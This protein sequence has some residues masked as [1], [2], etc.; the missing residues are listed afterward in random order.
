MLS[1]KGIKTK[2]YGIL[3]I[4]LPEQQMLQNEKKSMIFQSGESRLRSIRQGGATTVAAGIGGGA[5]GL[6]IRVFCLGPP[7]KWDLL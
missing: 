6:I 5:L 3:D 4:Q 7:V 2:C 1:Q